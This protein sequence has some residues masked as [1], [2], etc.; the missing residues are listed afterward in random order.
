MATPETKPPVVS[1][2]VPAE[3][4][5]P[6]GLFRRS[7]LAIVL[8]DGQ[9][10][11]IIDANDAF[12]SLSGYERPELGG[13]SVH[14]IHASEPNDAEEQLFLAVACGDDTPRHL[15]LRTK[16]GSEMEMEVRAVPMDG[17]R[18]TLLALYI[19]DVRDERRVER[20]KGNLQSQLWMAQKH[21][22]VGR[23]AAGIAHDFNNLLSAVM[24]TTESLRERLGEDERVGVDLDIIS[25]AG[26][27]ARELTGELLA[28]SGRQA[29]EP[30]ALSLNDVV[31]GMESLVRRT[32]PANIELSIHPAPG[33]TAVSADPVQMQQVL[34]NL[35]VNARDAMPE[36]G[37]LVIALH[38][39]EVDEE[40]ARA[41]T[42]IRPGPH[43]MLGVT[44]TGVGMDEET[45]ARIFE[46]FFTTRER[47]NGV[48]L[49]LATV[50][51][52]VKQSGG[53]IWVT[54]QPGMGTTFRVYL[55][56]IS[57][58][59]LQPYTPE[60]RPKGTVRRGSEHILLAE[61]NESVRMLTARMLRDLGYEVTE[62]CSGNEALS[63]YDELWPTEGP[64]PVDLL[65][66]DVV[67]PEISG[68][69]LVRRLRLKKEDLKALFISGYLGSSGPEES[70][71]PIEPLLPKPF[72]K[73]E[74]A[75]ALRTVLER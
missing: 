56:L 51:G 12:C 28:F 5:A 29:L 43:V 44:D 32:L 55:P 10:H 3:E 25:E 20:D 50:Y 59:G 68:L 24:L 9:S 15:M 45:Q 35:V 64:H 58:S 30:R 72:T 54:S 23:L 40:F 21:E 27:R 26:L 1:L 60:E 13:L 61:D 7:P 19:R 41:Y 53:S 42:S 75:H 57:E 16:D 67:M 36:G 65:V 37:R 49:G 74:L 22:A 2:S 17:V 4:P 46:P 47:G 31:L 70:Q 6:K 33:T 38:E 66:T 52:I 69:E 73:V 63:I 71:V 39:V 14:K 48:G 11:C 18:G 62:A 34:L 8:V